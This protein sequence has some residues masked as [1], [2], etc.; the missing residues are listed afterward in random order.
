M[1]P[2]SHVNLKIL[3]LRHTV[4]QANDSCHHL[5]VKL[6]HSNLTNILRWEFNKLRANYRLCLF[7][8]ALNLKLIFIVFFFHS[9]ILLSASSISLKIFIFLRLFW[10][11]REGVILI[12][13]IKIFSKRMGN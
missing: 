1:M 2:V 8:F 12:Y 5:L 6:I 11:L 9:S 7:H 3:N 13:V 4:N 10:R